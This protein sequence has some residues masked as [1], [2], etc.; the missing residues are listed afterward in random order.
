MTAQQQ[1]KFKLKNIGPQVK[2]RRETVA[3]PVL[4]E[5]KDYRVGLASCAWY[6]R[7]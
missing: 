1:T 2:F 5:R 3:R 4:F 7:S 6:V